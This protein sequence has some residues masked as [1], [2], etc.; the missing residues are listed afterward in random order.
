MFVKVVIILIMISVYLENPVLQIV[1]VFQ[2]DNVNVYQDI[3]KIRLD[4]A[5][6]VHKDQYG[7]IINA[8]ILAEL[9]RFITMEQVNVNVRLDMDT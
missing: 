7:I 3:I 1:S 6:D 4:S 9:I 2:M 8:F 5:Q